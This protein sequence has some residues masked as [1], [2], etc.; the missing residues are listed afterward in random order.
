[1]KERTES[2]KVENTIMDI[3]GQALKGCEQAIASGLKFQE[4]ATRRWTEM[5]TQAAPSAQDW[6]KRFN[7]FMAAAKDLGPA[8][9]K[10]SEEMLE[11][12]NKNSRTSAEIYRKA[13]EAAQACN[14][15]DRQAAWKDVWGASMTAIRSNAETLTQINNRIVD[16]WIGFVEKSAEAAQ[17]RS[18]QGV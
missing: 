2:T 5:M 8:S 4:E 9:Q 16:S 3:T 12:V 15:S 11:L 1:M 17:G 14:P 6:Q 13:A 7:A 10:R 18:T